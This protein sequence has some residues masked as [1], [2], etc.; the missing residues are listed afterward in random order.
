MCRLTTLIALAFMALLLAVACLGDGSSPTLVPTPDPMTPVV[1][2]QPA[3]A[4]KE[5]PDYGV[6]DVNPLGL[7]FGG[8][9]LPEDFVLTGE[10]VLDNT[11]SIERFVGQDLKAKERLA[12]LYREWGWVSGGKRQW[13]AS[14]PS[15]LTE[16]A[17]QE[18]LS[19]LLESVSCSVELYWDTAGASQAFA[20]TGFQT[21]PL[22]GI[23]D[24]GT[25]RPVPGPT[26][27]AESRQYIAVHAVAS[28]SAVIFRTRNVL[29]RVDVGARTGAADELTD[30]TETL[31]QVLLERLSRELTLVATPS[32][33]PASEAG[34]IEGFRAFAP[35]IEEAVEVR[36]TRFFAERARTLGLDCPPQPNEVA[37][38]KDQP[39]GTTVQVFEARSP[40]AGDIVTLTD[41]QAELKGWFEAARGDLSDEY[42]P[43]ALT[44]YAIASTNP[45]SSQ[46]TEGDAIIT[47]IIDS[48]GDLLPRREVRVFGWNFTT[49]RWEFGWELLAALPGGAQY[50]SG[51]CK[52][53]THWERWE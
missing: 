43:G 18:E 10:L 36:D 20:E 45:D 13:A 26:V 17:A 11:T 30:Y 3:T 40:F 9:A 31:A 24:Q 22:L 51:E 28:G 39:E 33:T 4:V 47:A 46:E 44:L 19:T 32:H 2:S 29:G 52:N 35:Q 49:S 6:R 12:Q 23:P 42:G 53:C 8:S 21:R 48:P 25:F 27:G 1:P 50:L 34:G 15:S 14:A 38:C 5:G 37:A 41:Y 16:E 7:C